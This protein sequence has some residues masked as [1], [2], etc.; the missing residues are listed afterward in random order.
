[1]YRFL[2]II[3]F[4]FCFSQDPTQGKHL[5]IYK[6]YEDYENKT[7]QDLGPIISVTNN[8]RY[9]VIH[10]NRKKTFNISKYWGFSI[11]EQF[12]LYSKENA[13]AVGFLRIQ[14][15][16]FLYLEDD[17]IVHRSV[18]GGEG[19][20]PSFNKT[21]GYYYSESLN[22]KIFKISKIVDIKNPS[23]ELIPFIECIKE[24]KERYDS[25][26]KLNGYSKCIFP[27]NE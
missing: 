2:L 8:K 10:N 23:S 15:N 17:F 6:T 14:Y 5:V 25:Q 11:G 24:G 1:M 13:T 3:V 27:E 4:N 20:F 16:L 21:E 7:Y 19:L 18:W 22:S 12:F 9:E 26:S